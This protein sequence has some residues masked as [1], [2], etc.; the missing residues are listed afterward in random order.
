[1]YPHH[2]IGEPCPV[3]DLLAGHFGEE[4]GGYLLWNFTCFPCDDGIAYEQARALVAADKVGL[5]KEYIDSEER[6]QER[7]MREAAETIGY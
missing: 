5:F 3:A 4:Y 1:M 2:A 6:E 7:A